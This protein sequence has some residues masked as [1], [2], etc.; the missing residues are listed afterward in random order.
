MIVRRDS[1]YENEVTNWPRLLSLINKG[2]S[3]KGAYIQL[4][5]MLMPV[6]TATGTE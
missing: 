2:R 4:D 1:A 5:G 3:R 6:H